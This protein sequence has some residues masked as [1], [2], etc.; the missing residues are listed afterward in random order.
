MALNIE[1]FDYDDIACCETGEPYLFKYLN[2]RFKDIDVIEVNKEGAIVI[3]TI[4]S[5]AIL[6]KIYDD[7]GEMFSI[8]IFKNEEFYMSL[9]F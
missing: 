2:L 6:L 9:G 8:I 1:T 4:T 5:N 7:N 3:D